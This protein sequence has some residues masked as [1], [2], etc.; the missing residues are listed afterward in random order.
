[1][2]WWR[3]SPRL[4]LRL[5]DA[6]LVPE[7]ALALLAGQRHRSPKRRLFAI[8]LSWGLRRSCSCPSVS[9][10]DSSAPVEGQNASRRGQPRIP[11]DHDGDGHELHHGRARDRRPLS[12]PRARRL[13]AS[14]ADDPSAPREGRRTPHYRRAGAR[15]YA[16]SILGLF[17]CLFVGVAAFYWMRTWAHALTLKARRARVAAD[18]AEKVA[19]TFGAQLAD[20]LHVFGSRT[21]ALGFL[22]ETTIYWG[23]SALGLGL[24]A[25]GSGVVHADG[26]VGS[27][28]EACA[29]LSG[30]LGCAVMLPRAAGPPR[31]LPGRP[32]RWDG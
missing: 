3:A 22:F 17:S 19:G 30:W 29:L 13:A 18:L 20:G 26:S 4:R 11:E 14:R 15:R 31:R 10:S 6:D 7:H 27:F 9:G 5:R 16:Y 1:M 28:G 23:L 24:L 8:S 2:R 21:H 25:W 12:E 32:L